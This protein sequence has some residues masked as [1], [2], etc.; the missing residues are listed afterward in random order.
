MRAAVGNGERELVTCEISTW[1]CSILFRA[2]RQLA[3]PVDVG[4]GY[5]LFAANQPREGD[6]AKSRR[7]DIFAVRKGEQ[8]TRITNYEMYEV[9]SLSLAKDKI[10]FGAAGKRGFEPSSCPPSDFLKCDKSDIYALDF[11]P[12][13]MTLLNR[14]NLLKPLF[15]VAGYSTQPV[16]SPDGKRVAFKNTNRQGNSWRYNTAISD[17]SGSIE[18]GVSA[19][20][21]AFSASAFVGD[22][23]FVN[24]VFEDRYR[25]LRID[26][27]SKKVD[28]FEV[29][30]SPEY[31]KSVETIPL[32][33]DGLAN[34]L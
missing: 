2:P 8:P 28:G 6:D 10:V 31:L 12:Q 33:I 14:P 22:F 32:S 20:G 5:V 26:A 17:L 25:I 29:K 1:R 21:F 3:A 24:E 4:N 11:D 34:A 16:V 23:L 7:F 18:G 13:R 9:Q 15:A 30:H 27:A 19:Q